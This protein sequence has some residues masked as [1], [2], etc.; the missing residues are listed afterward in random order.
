MAF[1]LKQQ[2][3]LENYNL[4]LYVHILLKNNSKY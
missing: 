2:F 4:S 3:G 1:N